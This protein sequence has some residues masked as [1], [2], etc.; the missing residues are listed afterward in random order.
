L[1]K[2]KETDLKEEIED[3]IKR[4]LGIFLLSFITIILSVILSFQGIG[5]VVRGENTNLSLFIIV[6]SIFLLINAIALSKGNHIARILMMV[7]MIIFFIITSLDNPEAYKTVVFA[8]LM[9][10]LASKK[11]NAYFAQFRKEK[12][13]ITTD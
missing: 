8:V 9:M 11:A 12:V 13:T 6:V 10:P 7:S 3:N 1:F 5:S 4:P 2:K